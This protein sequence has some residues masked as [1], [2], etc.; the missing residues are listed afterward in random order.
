MVLGCEEGNRD[1]QTAR[2]A[3][4][5]HQVI[6]PAIRRAW[7]QTMF[8]IIAAAERASSFAELVENCKLHFDES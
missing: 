1:L 5:R 6:V 8:A 3:R 7:F 4:V 2:Q